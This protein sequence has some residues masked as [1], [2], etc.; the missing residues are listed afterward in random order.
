M[1]LKNYYLGDSMKVLW[2]ANSYMPYWIASEVGLKANNS[3]GWL[4]DLLMR[5][6][7]ESKIKFSIILFSSLTTEV[8]EM[9]I[10]DTL[11][12]VIPKPRGINKKKFISETIKYINKFSPDIVHFHGTEVE[13]YNELL[14]GISSKTT[15]LLT[16]QGLPGKI[17]NSFKKGFGFYDF[18]MNPLLYGE[19]TF[20]ELYFKFIHVSEIEFVKKIRFATGRTTWDK[21]YLK[22]INPEIDYFKHNYNLRDEFYNSNK[23]SYDSISAHQIYLSALTPSYKGTQM[24]LNTL[25]R[26]KSNYPQLR[27][28][29]PKGTFSSKLTK[30]FLNYINKKIKR[31]GLKD[32]IEILDNLDSSKVIEQMLQS[33][34]VL[35]PSL[36]ENASAT[37]C[38]AQYLGVP[39]IA[40]FTGGMTELMK[41]QEDGFYF[42]LD[43]SDVLF[44][45]ISQLF[46]S[47]EMCLSFSGKSIAVA[48][49]RHDRHKNYQELLDIY[50]KIIK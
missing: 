34:L 4:E 15:A 48:E 25:K 14:T 35:I 46:N 36:V 47:K 18:A 26:L 28:V 9:N 11:I 13:Y 44:E 42:N 8:K 29:V 38:E 50:L 22:E 5:L 33:R 31:L 16:I 6:I 27:V 2:I 1:L 43:D 49:L 39:I 37:L 19:L 17:I 7:S 45:R 23:W 3:G 21:A 10:N 12:F 40:A 32:S 24:I 41:H 30:G 20:L